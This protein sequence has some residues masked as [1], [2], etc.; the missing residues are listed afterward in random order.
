MFELSS[1][2]PHWSLALVSIPGKYIL[3]EVPNT[4]P[5]NAITK[6][7]EA[8]FQPSVTT[9][10]TLLSV[11]PENIARL[12][13]EVAKDFELDKNFCYYRL[14][15][16]TPK[17]MELHQALKDNFYM[18][19]T[20]RRLIS[21]YLNTQ[22]PSHKNRF[23][24]G[25]NPY[26]L[27]SSGIQHLL[28]RIPK[29]PTETSLFNTNQM[30]DPWD[31]VYSN[32][33]EWKHFSK[34]VTSI[35]GHHIGIETLRNIAHQKGYA[36]VIPYFAPMGSTAD[37]LAMEAAH[38]LLFAGVVEYAP[39]GSASKTLEGLALHPG[40]SILTAHVRGKEA[41]P[42][43]GFGRLHG[44]NKLWEAQFVNRV[45]PSAMARTIAIDALPIW[46]SENVA[47]L[48]RS[49]IAEVKRIQR[50]EILAF[51]EETRTNLTSYLQHIFNSL[52]EEFKEG[53][54]IKPVESCCSG[55]DDSLFTTMRTKEE[56]LANV[57]VDYF[58]K[59]FADT[60]AP[61]TQHDLRET[62]LAHPKAA[63]LV[64]HDLLLNPKEVIAQK[65]LKL[66]KTAQ[67]KPFECRVD[68]MQ[69]KALKSELRYGSGEY[70]PQEEKE[71]AQFL[72][73]FFAK[74][75]YQNQ[76]LC[77]GADLALGE[78]GKW[79]I[80]EFNLGAESGFLGFGT[81]WNLYISN[82]LGKNTPL[83]ETY[84]EIMKKP[85]PS[86]KEF[87]YAL[88][89]TVLNHSEVNDLPNVYTWFRNKYCEAFEI[90]KTETQ[91][92]SILANLRRLFDAVPKEH[93]ECADLLIAGAE[94]YM[95]REL[96]ANVA[97]V[98]IKM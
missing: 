5:V 51:S 27:S 93:R 36:T 20:T 97:S 95:A 71:A 87:L 6:A 29:L 19:T 65:A 41:N 8:R 21:E 85:I 61:M 98:G 96:L 37:I 49:I 32:S 74:A 81:D 58:P 34:P 35:P 42:H 54:F 62:L 11:T 56:N 68:F 1:F 57:F 69:G 53:A 31:K 72:D 13:E 44:K 80:I 86:Q 66:A 33:E 70:Y 24:T 55:D 12:I 23:F 47:Q 10:A 73:R 46:N 40:N 90:N 28:A 52:K 14:L 30:E 16:S 76:A 84:E 18:Q 75:R 77:G 3:L 43:L 67:G 9:D 60:S 4:W 50:Q 38:R 39:T 15:D 59:I 48:R 17:A 82:F 91:K 78:D 26:A 88:E 2:L 94:S 7:I 25:V 45:D 64:V 92:E 63:V 89:S 79:H 22:T 83:I